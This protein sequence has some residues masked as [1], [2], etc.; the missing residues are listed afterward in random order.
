MLDSFLGCTSLI[1]LGYYLVKINE[2]RSHSTESPV[3][4]TFANEA[5]TLHR[6]QSRAPLVLVGR[7]V[8]LMFL[9]LFLPKRP[10]GSL[11]LQLC[12]DTTGG[13][14]CDGCCQPPVHSD[15][16]GNVHSHGMAH[17]T[18]T[19]P[20]FC[21]VLET[22][23]L[24]QGCMESHVQALFPKRATVSSIPRVLTK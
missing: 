6:F 17:S 8:I 7:N 3:C 4:K 10:P 1:P 23:A 21:I 13:R 15:H 22:R 11:G 18:P 14:R 20:Y 12:Q 9:R 19:A 5:N 2:C 16:R 24:F